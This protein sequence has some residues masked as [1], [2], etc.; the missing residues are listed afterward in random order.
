MSCGA[1]G[2]CVAATTDKPTC[3]DCNYSG[4]AKVDCSLKCPSGT[5]LS[6]WCSS[7]WLAPPNTKPCSDVKSNGCV[8]PLN[9]TCEQL[10]RRCVERPCV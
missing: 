10:P 8:L 5:R 1:Q 7:P 2:E 9:N 4:G 3:I 6:T